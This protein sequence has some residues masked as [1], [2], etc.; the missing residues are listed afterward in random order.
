MAKITSDPV[1]EQHALIF[2]AWKCILGSER[3]AIYVSGPITTG[4]RLIA[5]REHGSELADQSA[6]L[7]ANI[8]EIIDAAGR[9]RNDTGRV[10]VEPG[11][12]LV[13]SWSQINYL[14]LW[15]SLIERHIAE[16]RFLDG[17]QASIG[18][19]LEYERA[20]EHEISCLRL[21]GTAISH[22]EAI[23]LVKESAAKLVNHADELLVL[24][25]RRLA[26]VAERLGA[27]QP[28]RRG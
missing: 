16:V 2:Q 27:A 18:C 14:E 1:S 6:V 8:A 11:S 26:D 12:L 4:P 24:L 17:W 23:L 5:M 22:A 3:H 13:Q 28:K 20:L 10:V 15:T 25:G 9:L 19:V 7:S 21:D